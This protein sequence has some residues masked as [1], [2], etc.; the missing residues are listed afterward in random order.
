MAKA[1][2]SKMTQDEV[3][4]IC[5]MR[6]AGA[7]I[8]DIAAH[9]GR[10]YNAIR[11]RLRA[12]GVQVVSRSAHVTGVSGEA[13]SDMSDKLRL[14][15]E[16][17]AC[18]AHLADLARAYPAGPPFHALLPAAAGHV[19][20]MSIPTPFSLVGSPAALCEG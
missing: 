18:A 10:S 14:D 8:R 2:V 7:P 17:D 19:V 16:A 13:I 4:A 12:S 1:G 9:F 5:A 11:E 15:N 3:T 6:I 20:R